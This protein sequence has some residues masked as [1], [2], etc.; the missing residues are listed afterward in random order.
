MVAWGLF[1][2]T[3]ISLLLLGHRH[4][5]IYHVFSFTSR[6]LR[7]RNGKTL[8]NCHADLFSVNNKNTES[9]KRE[10]RSPKFLQE[11]FT[12]PVLSVHLQTRQVLCIK[13]ALVPN[14]LDFN[15]SFWQKWYTLQMKGYASKMQTFYRRKGTASLHFSKPVLYSADTYEISTGYKRSERRLL[16]K[17]SWIEST[18]KLQQMI[19]LCNQICRS[20]SE[21]LDW[22]INDCIDLS[23]PGNIL[24]K[25]RILKK[26]NWKM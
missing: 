6:C 12:L 18:S 16:N 7:G 4:E 11:V 17:E 5:H 23:C 22:D 9:S 26:P 21:L 20:R 3:T 24:W 14:I 13:L 1:Q 2:D 19:N 10:Q 25:N 8:D 15:K